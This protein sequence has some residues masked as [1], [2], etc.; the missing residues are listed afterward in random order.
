MNGGVRVENVSHI[1][2]IEISGYSISI[3]VTVAWH[4]KAASRRVEVLK[5]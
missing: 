4:I 5:Y 1:E 2:M 3:V